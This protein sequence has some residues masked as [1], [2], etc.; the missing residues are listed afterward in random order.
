MAFID[1]VGPHL[2]KLAPVPFDHGQCLVV[3]F[4]DDDAVFEL[5]SKDDQGIL[6]ALMDVNGLHRCLIKVR[7]RAQC[8]D[9]LGNALGTEVL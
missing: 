5:V 1:D 7:I 4:L 6:N 9:D 2:V 3:L 8:R